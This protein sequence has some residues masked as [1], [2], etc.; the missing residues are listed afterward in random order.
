MNK[1]DLEL[2]MT[3]AKQIEDNFKFK[4]VSNGKFQTLWYCDV[5]SGLWREDGVGFLMALFNHYSLPK[6]LGFYKKVEFIISTNNIISDIKFRS[7]EAYIAL[8]DLKMLDLK[9]LR[10]VDLNQ[11]NF[12][13]KKV[14]VSYNLKAR[15]PR[16]FLDALEKALPDPQ[17]MFLLLQGLSTLLL[18]RT[19]DADDIFILQGSGQNGKTT[20]LST[21][22]FLFK[23][24]VSAIS[25][26]SLQENRFMLGQV[27]GKLA[28]IYSD[29]SG[30]R[31]KDINVLKMLSSGD[32]ATVD[33]KFQR[34]HDAII[35]VVQMYSCNKMPEIEDKSFAIGRRFI[36]I[37]FTEK[38]I[39]TDRNIRE[40]LRE[41]EEQ[42]RI[43]T[44]LLRIARYTKKH[45]YLYRP[46]E[47][48][49]LDILEERG[50]PI[51][52]FLSD[53][54]GYVKE[55]LLAKSEKDIVYSLYTKFCKQ[56]GFVVQEKNSFTRVLHKKGFTETRT[57]NIKYW[58]G[59]KI[60]EDMIPKIETKQLELD[61]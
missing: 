28:N 42:T 1:I 47:K 53:K 4:S 27:E 52:Q 3:Y 19:Q 6:D 43:F 61:E 13:Q 20:I 41:P 22:T 12:F 45:G 14:D 24:F 29:I 16:I 11:D 59:V 55:D 46:N 44:M 54:S 9:D 51:I 49:V 36:P 40:K 8:N 34:P 21:I 26:H 39:I 25:M 2:A 48:E 32:L 15:P 37:E 17:K 38:I 23:E 60:N 31:L 5:K 30:M 7:P 10:V 33:N 56:N 18:V 58:K 35:K 57:D 50:N